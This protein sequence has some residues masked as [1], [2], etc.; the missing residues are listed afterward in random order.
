MKWHRPQDGDERFFRKFAFLP[1]WDDEDI[2]WLEWV[3]IS[4]EYIGLEYSGGHSY[5]KTIQKLQHIQRRY[6]LQRQWR[7][8]YFWNIHRNPGQLLYRLNDLPD[9][10]TRIE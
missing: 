3:E 5:W 2:Y 4:Q 7:P 1:I 6:C 8:L 10:R 9:S